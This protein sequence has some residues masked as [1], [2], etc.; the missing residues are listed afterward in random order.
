MSDTTTLLF[1]SA[2]SFLLALVIGFRKSSSN[3][4]VLL[5]VGAGFVVLCGYLMI[6]GNGSESMESGKF[7]SFLILF[8]PGFIIYFFLPLLPGYVIGR[9]VQ[10]KLRQKS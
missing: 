8:I 9:F 3:T 5:L 6:F 1:G 10:A 2:V 4:S 7:L